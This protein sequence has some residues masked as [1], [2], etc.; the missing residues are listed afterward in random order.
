MSQIIPSYVHRQQKF[1]RGF[2]ILLLVVVAVI[3]WYLPE[4]SADALIASISIAAF[5]LLPAWLWIRDGTF[6]LP[7]FPLFALSFLWAYALPLLGESAHLEAVRDSSK[8][9][10]G[11]IITLGLFIGT[12]TWFWFRRGTPRRG[13][14]LQLPIHR[15]KG[16]L[17]GAMAAYAVFLAGYVGLWFEGVPSE[18]LTL[19]RVVLSSLYVL[20]VFVHFFEIGNGKLRGVRQAVFIVLFAAV[21]LV[22]SV[23]LL[24]IATMISV[25]IALTGF[26]LGRG[27]VPWKMALLAVFTFALLHAGKGE[28]RDKYWFSMVQYKPQ[29]AEYL[30]LYAEWLGH[31]LDNFSLSGGGGAPRQREYQSLRERAGLIYLFLLVYESSPDRIPYLHGESYAPIPRLLIPRFI[32]PDRDNTHEGTIILNVHY[33]LQTRESAMTATIGW[34]LIGE[35]HANFGIPGV[36]GAF[37]LL[38]FFYAR[39]ERWSRGRDI[40]SFRGMVALVILTLAAQSGVTAAV[41]VTALFQAFC[42]LAL[43]AVFAMERRQLRKL[44]DSVRLATFR[45]DRP[46]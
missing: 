43:L 17:L 19:F 3:L 30:G 9:A 44:V 36:I 33:G 40:F 27:R 39:V 6:E 11:G 29:P 14:T 20:A 7:I 23:T 35:S 5:S 12:V 25:L 10:T 38:G 2:L 28:M 22:S 32:N 21:E 18:L 13:A 1:E 31:G 37:V 45:V 15:M 8:L 16:I 34:D 24:L 4:T 41:Y 46:R 26:S 42:A